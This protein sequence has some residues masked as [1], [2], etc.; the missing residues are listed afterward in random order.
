MN[1]YKNWWKQ[2]IV[3]P[4]VMVWMRACSSVLL[5]VDHIK[6]VHSVTLNPESRKV[7]H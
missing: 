6:S 2:Q 1:W 5:S 3:L 4:L 7:R